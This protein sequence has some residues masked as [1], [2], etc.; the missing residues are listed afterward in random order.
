MGDKTSH[1]RM[2]Q[3]VRDPESEDQNLAAAV[4]GQKFKRRKSR[5]EDEDENFD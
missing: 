4:A 3:K 5:D 2:N 1:R